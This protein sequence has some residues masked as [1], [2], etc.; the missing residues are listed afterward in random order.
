M[1]N[2]I[3]RKLTLPSK[4]A[5]P[6]YLRNSVCVGRFYHK[7]SKKVELK[8]ITVLNNRPNIYNH[9]KVLSNGEMQVMHLEKNKLVIRI[10]KAWEKVSAKK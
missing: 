6:Y 4:Q 1:V 9:Y 2:F 3:A 5:A 7:I 10:T 8:E